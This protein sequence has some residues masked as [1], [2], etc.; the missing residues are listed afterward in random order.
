M[1]LGNTS[2]EFRDLISGNEFLARSLENQFIMGARYSYTLNTQVNEERKKE[3]TEDEFQ[4]NHFYLNAK[5]ETAGNLVHL[6][7]GGQFKNED[8]GDSLQIFGSSYAQF[9]RAELDFR[10]Y[11]QLDEKNQIASRVTGGTG[12]A[13]GNSITMPYIRQFSTGG[14]NSI[15]AFP[16]RSIGPGTYDVQNSESDNSI[17]FLDQ[18]A[19]IK[20]EGSVEYRYDITKLIKTAVFIDAGNIWLWGSDT[21]RIGSQFNRKTFLKELAVGTGAGLRFDFN[22]FVLRFDLAFPVRKPYLPTGQRWVW[23]EVAPGNKA[24]RRENLILNIAIGYP[25]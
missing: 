11:R 20:L 8:S 24:W 14:S 21:A 18:R 3:F 23:N 10:Y 15:R 13:Y 19:D 1:R 25:F 4:R 12:Y 6:L 22:F 9:V 5:L 7:R 2:T 16:A 17:L